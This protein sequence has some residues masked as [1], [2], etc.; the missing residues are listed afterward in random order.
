MKNVV[1]ENFIASLAVGTLIAFA[2]QRFS[3]SAIQKNYAFYSN[4]WNS[5]II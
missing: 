5:R 4:D 2:P 3:P 1:R